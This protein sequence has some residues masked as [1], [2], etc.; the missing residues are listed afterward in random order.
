[1]YKDKRVSLI[2]PAYNEEGSIGGVLDDF[3][4]HPLLDEIIV[5]DNNC[6]DRTAELAAA[7]GARVLSET[8]K[9]YGCALRCG[10]RGAQGDLLVLTEADGSFRAE[11]L[12]K[13]LAFS[14]DCDLVLGNRTTWR[15]IMPGARMNS[16]I[17]LANITVGKLVQLCWWLSNPTRLSDVGC[18]YRLITRPA[19]ER[20]AGRLRDEG[21]EFSTEMMA[22][23]LASGLK[24]VEVPVHY[25]IR[26][27]GESKHSGSYPGLAKTAL[28]MLRTLWRK[29]TER[30]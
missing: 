30:R 25:G 14:G 29:R 12:E 5:V 17:R 19:Y 11:D 22:E 9:G 10:L 6:T 7:G 20:I 24:I 23:A 28:R 27:L 4:A 13:L 8:A 26:A 3:G 15:F 16:I 18:T 21:P 2:I 1:M